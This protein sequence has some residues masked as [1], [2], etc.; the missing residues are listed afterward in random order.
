MGPGIVTAMVD[1]DAA[2]IVTYSQAGA[3]YGYRLLWILS[4][5]TLSLIVL[6]EICARMGAVTGKGLADLIRERFGVRITLFAMATLIVANLGTAIAEFAGVASA[7]RIFLPGGWSG[8]SFVLIPLAGL[9]I[10]T[11]VV[12]GTYRG[13]ERIFLYA[14]LVYL[15]YVVAALWVRPPWPEVLRAAVIPS[16]GSDRPDSGYVGLIIAVI[17]TTIAPWTQ[18]YVQSAVRDKGLTWSQYRLTWWD[19]VIGSTMTGVIGFFIMVT[20]AATLHP[21]GITLADSDPAAAAQAL[22]PLVGGFATTLFGIGLL[23]AS[24]F[25]ATIVPLST[26]YA[27]TEALGW[28]SG[29]GKRI[30]E[31]PLFIGVYTGVIVIAAAV[32]LFPGVPLTTILIASQTLNGILLPIILV[33]MLKLVNDRRIMGEHVNGPFMN[34]IAYLTTVI[35][36]GLSAFLLFTGLTG[37]A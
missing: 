2:G 37:A 31:A 27:V 12:R 24:L 23:N 35:L 21:Q 36:I 3:R 5:V 14:S 6:Q 30:R 28:E 22:M 9:G 15:T 25:G 33:L 10:W 29:L 4:L 26:A 13:V 20:C 18:F 17:G 32:S 19:V 34:V 16:F 7:L 11:L 1:N 8:V